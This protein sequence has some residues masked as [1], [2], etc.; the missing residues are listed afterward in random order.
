MKC[1][2]CSYISFDY[3][4]VC[5]KCNKDIS[6]EQE[7]LNIPSL[8]PDPPSLLGALMGAPG[9]AEASLNAS[10]DIPVIQQETQI[11]LGDSQNFPSESAGLGDSQEMDL[12]LELDTEQAAE[13]KTLPGKESPPGRAPQPEPGDLAISLDE[14]AV[15]Q[16][17]DGKAGE[18]EEIPF[19]LEEIAIESKQLEKEGQ[20]AGGDEKLEIDLSDLSLEDGDGPLTLEPAPPEG[21][22]GVRGLEIGSLSLEG[23]EGSVAEEN[24]E[25]TLSLEDLKV[26]ETGELEIG[27]TIPS[28]HGQHKVKFM[29]E[30]QLELEPVSP[31]PDEE[32]NDEDVKLLLGDDTI[33]IRAEMAE[34]EQQIDLD[35]LDIELDL[36]GPDRK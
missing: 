32:T 3:N 14:A 24:E 23:Q 12:A 8:K 16:P 33:E 30:M 2:K 11:S 25:I 28:V 10:G 20:A 34:G 6:L 36:D 22:G 4:Q 27:K 15:F 31:Q 18:G 1:P 9:E 26:N 19:D 7:K 17:A 5:P 13:Q 21:A 29:D 35:N